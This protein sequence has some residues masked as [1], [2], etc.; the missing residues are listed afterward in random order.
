M[1]GSLP[2]DFR[3]FPR[4]CDAQGGP[5]VD[6]DRLLVEAISAEGQPVRFAIA[7]DELHHF[8]SFLLVSAGKISAAQSD[9][10]GPQQSPTQPCR[11]IPLTA[12][13]IGEPED[14]EGYLALSIGC[15]ELLFS[16]PISAFEPVGRSMLLAGARADHKR[17][18]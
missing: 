4:I 14:G 15:A 12:I 8:V 18:A 7:L 17:S 16:A 10:D 6:G 1:S 13:A 5:S 9:R 11:P 3:E 2:K